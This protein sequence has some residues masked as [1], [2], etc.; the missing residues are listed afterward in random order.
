MQLDV[1]HVY[2]TR[3]IAGQ[4][5]VRAFRAMLGVLALETLGFAVWLASNK[6]LHTWQHLWLQFWPWF[7]SIM[8]AR[9]LVIAY[10]TLDQELENRQALVRAR[11]NKAYE[12]AWKDIK[13]R[14]QLP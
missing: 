4:V 2:P 3:Y 6:S 10:K 5:L 11:Q 12:D 8:L 7:L 1:K 9:A 14:E 13:A